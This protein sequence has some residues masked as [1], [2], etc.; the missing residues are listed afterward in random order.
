MKKDIATLCFL[1]LA[2]L[3][4][5][6]S[7]PRTS[8]GADLGALV[9]A[10]PQQD[11]VEERPSESLTLAE[12]LAMRPQAPLPAALA[13]VRLQDAPR[14]V[15]GSMRLERV[16]QECQGW[17]DRRL[18]RLGELPQVTRVR[19]ATELLAKGRI[20]NDV[21]LRRIG[22]RL[23]ADVLLVYTIDSHASMTSGVLEDLAS[24]LLPTQRHRASATARALLMDVRSGY[25]YASEQATAHER[26]R[27]SVWSH[28]D[29]AQRTVE[30]AERGAMDGLVERLGQVWSE[31]EAEQG[32]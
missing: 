3:P 17:E 21:D 19:L 10:S 4:I 13:V 29:A 1:F 18:V 2:A 16:L 32:T 11:R 15:S 27:A 24:L 7:A 9:D 14:H 8:R 6:C 26:T 23:G 5:A 28:V 12:L 22:G 31:I 25:V 30:R 20:E